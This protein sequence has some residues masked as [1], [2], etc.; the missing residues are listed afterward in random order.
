MPIGSTGM[1][2]ESPSGRQRIVVVGTSLAGLRAAEALRRDGFEGSLTLIG[3]ETHFP[4]Y[5]RPPLS[6]QL[7]SGAWEPDTA[8]LKVD[9]ALDVHL[10]LGRE[11]TGLDGNNKVVQLDDGT[12]VAYDGLV[13]ATGATPRQPFADAAALSG[14]HTLRTLDDCLRLKERL[15]PGVRIAIVGAGFIGAEVAATCRERDVEVTL[16]D[17]FTEPMLRVLGPEMGAVLGRLHARHGVQMQFGRAVSGFIGDERLEAVLL[18]SGDKVP[19]DVAVIAIGVTPNTA[20]LEGSG[21]KLGDGVICDEACFVTGLDDAVAAGDVARWY[22]PAL[23]KEVR[24]EHWSN[25]V[26]QAQAAARNLLARL[27][28]SGDERPFDVLPYFWSDQYNW[29]LQ[30]VGTQGD[31]VAVT[32]GSIDEEKFV[33]SY[34][35]AGK[36]VGALCVNWPAQ[37][38]KQRSRISAATN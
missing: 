34:H 25:A 2:S 11:A 19:A 21:A 16:I 18:D 7:L 13:I 5:D 37:V 10:L 8:R 36:L 38:P 32:D 14:V 6:K 20:W 12:K 35:T 24:I 15:Q 4:P 28:D 17:V 29:K 30:F 23:G 9:P 1:P 27:T 33:A 3:H 31:D 26:A 22:H